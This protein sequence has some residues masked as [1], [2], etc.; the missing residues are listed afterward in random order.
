MEIKKVTFKVALTF[1]I[2]RILDKEGGM[3]QRNCT[4]NYC[5]CTKR[6][7]EGLRTI[8]LSFPRKKSTSFLQVGDSV[9]SLTLWVWCFS[10]CDWV[11]FKFVGYE[12]LGRRDVVSWALA[13]ISMRGRWLLRLSTVRRLSGTWSFGFIRLLHD[14]EQDLHFGFRILKW[15]SS[16]GNGDSISLQ[17]QSEVA[18]R[19]WCTNWPSHF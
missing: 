17:V 10:C 4:E 1:S 14:E 11:I 19:P 3:V 7:K 15:A 6:K 12:W 18:R 9:V 5:Y 16:T 2:L 8:S 13:T